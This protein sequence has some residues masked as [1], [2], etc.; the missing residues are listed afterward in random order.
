[1]QTV[2]KLQI[3]PLW[4]FYMLLGGRQ[5]FFP[6]LKNHGSRDP[7]DQIR[8]QSTGQKV[9]APKHAYSENF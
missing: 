7:Q 3:L 5:R 9:I 8:G 6:P 2:I 4:N 1:M